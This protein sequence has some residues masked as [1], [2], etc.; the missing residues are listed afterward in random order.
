[1]FAQ[2]ALI[3]GQKFTTVNEAS[4]ILCLESVFGT[5]FSIMFAGEILSPSV[6]VGFVVIFIAMLISELKLDVVER[7]KRKSKEKLK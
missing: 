6:I 2:F 5:L 4:I 1:M 3:F 7:L